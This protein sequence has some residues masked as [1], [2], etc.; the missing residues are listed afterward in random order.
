MTSSH[1][2]KQLSCFHYD[3][4][5][6][7]I[8]EAVKIVAGERE[9]RMVSPN[10]ILFLVEGKINFLF[11][12]FP[13]FEL[14]NGQFVFLPAGSKYSFEAITD[15]LII[16]FRL[17]NPIMLCPNFSIEKLYNLHDSNSF[18]LHVSKTERFMVLDLHPR[19][20]HFLDAINN[21]L[22]D[23]IQCRC[24][25]KIKVKEVLLLLKAY[26]TKEDLHDFFFPI[27]S[28]DTA[29]SEYI[30]LH[31]QEFHS[32]GELAASMN[33]THKQ[34]KNRFISVFGKAPKE[35]IQEERARIVKQEIVET[36]KQFKQ[37]AIENKFASDTHFTRF[38]KKEFGITPTEIRERYRFKEKCKVKGW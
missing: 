21:S 28:E 35:W 13:L 25:F 9:E 2:I 7:P 27:L 31:W 36:G 4:G 18:D 6:K 29:F 11:Q 26:Y 34:F 5:E 15:S 24:Y 16:I 17:D 20:Q 12:D 19:I 30:R 1:E 10:E 38:C 37:I 14:L 3:Q 33:L 23:G 32:V 8:I 22:N